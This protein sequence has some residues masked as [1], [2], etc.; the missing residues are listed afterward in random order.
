MSVTRSR[1]SAS[2]VQAWQDSSVTSVSPITMGS[3]TLDAQVNILL[4]I[5]A[6]KNKV[7]SD[8]KLSFEFFYMPVEQ[9][10]TK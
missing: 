5:I 6:L 3:P 4:Y 1:V 9:H 8:V 10:F 2:V 7:I